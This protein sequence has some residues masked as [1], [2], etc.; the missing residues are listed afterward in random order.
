MNYF[1]IGV[2]LYMKCQNCQI[3]LT[4]NQTKWCSNKCKSDIAN[5]HLQSYQAQQKRGMDRKLELI[6]MKGGGC[7][8]CGYNKSIAALSFH[9]LDRSTKKF[10]LDLRSLS[11]RTWEKVLQEAEGCQL[12]CANCHMEIHHGVVGPMGLEPITPAL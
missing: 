9:H 7:E 3:E 4:G 6:R 8:V 10:N 5:A 11:N 2:I 12:V 1:I